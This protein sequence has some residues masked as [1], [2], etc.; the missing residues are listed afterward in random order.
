M[1]KRGTINPDLGMT[2]SAFFGK[3]RSALRRLWGYSQQKKD[4]LSRAKIPYTGEGR[5]KY[6][7]KCEGCGTEYGLGEKVATGLNKDGDWKQAKA[8]TVHH[9]EECGQLKGFED[10]S[11]FTEKLFCSSDKLKVL[12]YFCHKKEHEK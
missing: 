5:R 7:I 2:D 4:A 12:C 1:A 11:V 6:S 9:V 10:M 3:I 8:Y